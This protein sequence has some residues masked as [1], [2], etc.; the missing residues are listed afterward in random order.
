MSLAA[1]RQ[2]QEKAPD[3]SNQTFLR[4]DNFLHENY[5]HGITRESVAKEFR[6]TPSYVSR[7]YA[8]FGEGSFH[9]TLRRL[10]M[11][12]AVVLLKNTTLSIDEITVACAYS[13]TTFFIA[14]F[15]RIYGV[16]PGRFR[17]KYG[18]SSV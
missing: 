5:L 17:R 13:S 8:E 6:L 18:P 14:G 10:R 4:L 15:K 7:L 16:P 1:L 2:D 12:H 11:E 9:E 3:K